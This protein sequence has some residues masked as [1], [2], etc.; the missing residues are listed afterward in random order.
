[1]VTK[2]HGP[3]GPLLVGYD[4]YRDLK[5]D[6]LCRF[7]DKVVDLVPVCTS[8]AQPGQPGYS[9][10]MMMKVLLYA[11]CTGVFSSRRIAQ[12]CCESLP[13]LYLTRGEHPSHTSLCTARLTLEKELRLLWL[14]LISQAEACGIRFLG[15]ITVDSTKIRADVSEDSVIASKDYEALLARLN[16]LLARAEAADRTEDEEGESVRTGTE[17]E[18]GRLNMRRIVRSV[19]GD[20]PEGTI[21]PRLRKNIETGAKT[22]EAAAKEDLKHV[23]LTDP[24]ARMAPI[25]AGRRIAMSHTIETAVDA[26]ILVAARSDNLNTDNSRLPGLLEEV[27]KNDPAEVAEVLGDSGFY[28]TSIIESLLEQ[29]LNVIVPDSV[30]TGQMRRPETRLEFE[31]DSEKDSYKCPQGRA[32]DFSYESKERGRVYKAPTSCQDC[33]LAKACLRSKDSV[34]RTL[35]VSEKSKRKAAYLAKFFDP[36]IRSQYFARGPAVETVYAFIKRVLGMTRWNVRGDEA[37]ALESSLITSAYQIRKIFTQTRKMEA[38]K[39]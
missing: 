26:G 4:P 11:Y 12:N 23:S 38:A 21:S 33:P 27:R 36:E 20:C 37:V 6:H 9:P 25:G 10:S 22:L 19:K 18:A 24:D 16:E 8:G 3:A 15:K 29:G 5:Q 1:M 34:H 7:V 39:A 31:Y 13:Y 30:T 32:L 17:V 28:E 2:F 35:H 14:E